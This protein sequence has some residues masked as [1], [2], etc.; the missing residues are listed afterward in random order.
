MGKQ[1]KFRVILGLIIVTLSTG[2]LSAQNLSFQVKLEG[3]RIVLK[4]INAEGRPIRIPWLKRR[5]VAFLIST[6]AGKLLPDKRW[7]ILSARDRSSGAGNF[8]H[9]WEDHRPTEFGWISADLT[10]FDVPEEIRSQKRS[11][12]FLTVIVNSPHGSKR[13]LLQTQNYILEANGVTRSLRQGNRD[14]VP[15]S[16]LATFETE[17]M[18]ISSE[19]KN[20]NL[21]Y[22]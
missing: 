5:G 2:I 7:Q 15:K 17:K 4:V 1:V 3:D 19:E 6:V 20:P 18:K 14:E 16:V 9:Y 10:E 13:F 11:I 12:L 21:G 8:F 22:W